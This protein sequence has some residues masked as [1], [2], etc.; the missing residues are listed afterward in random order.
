VACVDLLGVDGAGISIMT[1]AGAV[2]IVGASS[3]LAAQVEEWQFSLGEGPCSQVFTD[4]QPGIVSDVAADTFGHVAGRCMSALD[5]EPAA[6][7]AKRG[8][9]SDRCQFHKTPRERT[10]TGAM[11]LSAPSHWLL[12]RRRSA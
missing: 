1:S 2:G 12:W 9:K 4:R 11:L 7:G 3:A 8:G 6:N 5:D 10:E